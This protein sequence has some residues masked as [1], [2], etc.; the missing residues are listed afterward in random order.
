MKFYDLRSA[1]I[2]MTDEVKY[3]HARGLLDIHPDHSHWVSLRDESEP[4]AQGMV[5]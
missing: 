3:L 2:D 5:F 1:E 4:L